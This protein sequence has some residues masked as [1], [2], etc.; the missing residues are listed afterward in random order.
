VATGVKARSI[1]VR[2]DPGAIFAE[3]PQRESGWFIQEKINF[4]AF[5]PIWFDPSTNIL[6]PSST[7]SQ[8]LIFPIT[9]PIQFGVN[10]L[11]FVAQ[12]TYAGSWYGYPIITLTGPYQSAVITNTATG[13]S[14]TMNVPLIGGAQRIINTTPGILSVVDATGVSYFSEL[15]P[16][17]NLVDFNLRPDPEAVGG[18]Q[19]ITVN[20]LGTSAGQGSAASVSYQNRYFGL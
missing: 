9:F 17:S 5:D 3:D 2:A 12:V 8:F 14:F 15:G 11:Q 13:V 1:V 18:V 7:Q 6:A 10:G 20:M 16:A 19:T 4:I